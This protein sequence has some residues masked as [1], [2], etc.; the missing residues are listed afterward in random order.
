MAFQ[1]GDAK[2]PET[3]P[4]VKQDQEKVAAAQKAEAAKAE[5][6]KKEAGRVQAVLMDASKAS[7]A[8]AEARKAA[9]QKVAEMEAEVI[10]AAKL[11]AEKAAIPKA[12][13]PEK[14]LVYPADVKLTT[15]RD[16]QTIV[17][18]LVYSNGITE[19][20]T[21][22]AQFQLSDNS[23][24]SLNGNQLIPKADGASTL[25]IT[26]AGFSV[27]VPVNVSQAAARPPISFKND[28]M[29]VFSKAGCNT[30]SCHG[31]ARGKD[32]FRLSLYGFDSKG[33]HH[34]L[35][36]EMLG[37]R[38][39]LA[40]PS[41]C[42]LMS[43]VTGEVSHSGGSLFKSDSP[44]YAT[45]MEWL[46]TGA[47]YDQ[48][49]VPKVVGIEIYPKKAVLDG[50][51]VTQQMTVR[52]KY[53]D[54]TDRDVTNL[55][56]FSTSN[57]NSAVISQTGVV[58]AKNRGESY[59]MARFDTHTLGA[60]FIV[61]PKAL[62]FNWKDIPE[63]NYVDVHINNKL[64]KLR[65]QPSELCSDSEFIR[66]VTLDICGVV[67]TPNE[68]TEFISDQSADKRAKLV[69]RLIGRKE[70][71]EI[72]VMK[73][74]E[75][76]Q[77]RSSNQVSYKATLLYYNWLQQQIASNVPVDE[78]VRQMLGSQGG[79]FKS[80]AT[81]YYQNERNNLKIAENVAQ[82]FMG[83]RI[84]CAQC[85]NHPFDR[86]T[87]DDYYS[88]AAFFSQIGRKPSDDPREQIIF[89]RGGGEVAHPVT[90]KAM[91]PKFLG[92]A[93][94]DVKGKDRRVVMANWLASPENPFFAKNLSNIVWAHFF[95][96]GIVNEVDDVRVS[97]PPVNPELLDEMAKRFVEYKYDFR[98]IVRDICNSRTYQLSTQ[99]NSSNESDLTNFSH[100]SLRRIRAE[101]LL[102]V[103]SNITET[104]NKFRGLPLGARAVQIA[105]GNTS[106]YFLQA[107]GR[108]SRATVCSCE[109]KMEPN[110][111][112]ALHLINGDAV[113]NKIKQGKLIQRLQK[114]GMTESEIIDELY[115]RCLSRKPN[116][117][118]R[119]KIVA[120]L[121][122]NENKLL[123][124]E[125]LFWALLNSREFV[126]NH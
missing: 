48:G 117:T 89:N 19:D 82:V 67:P 32:G 100:S 45:L 92:G 30:G 42:L 25:K 113:H 109:V 38:I 53:S 31:A 4:V 12:V 39:D 103:I 27:D 22:S 95:G 43:K 91:A 102:D 86:W 65:I 123:V 72:W 28:V 80:P 61:L 2:P 6:A 66:R 112:Q 36:R 62:E 64:K 26:H 13:V 15:V 107:F 121:A 46:Q 5:A 93:V 8:D 59:V 88:F 23:F 1:E 104:K 34:R 11:A 70:F 87:M 119:S 90:K 52:A 54:G 9:A 114:A 35:T 106:T 94:P 84:Q 97:N 115:L 49:E 69:D 101:V 47:N 77:I 122:A 111:S 68:V 85:H 96:Q 41:E 79:T 83:M 14:L 29:P 73:W 60:D 50:P 40:V 57:D 74:S 108:A 120:E 20:V 118:E 98:K 21:K 99:T 44:Y 110:L 33:D 75:L 56:Y 17:A 126:F 78:M 10:A 124:L 58:T 55:A 3:P 7:I 125:D 24:A 51:D 18:Q 37:R 105:D 81:N 76:L 16:S 63:N 71:V 116:E